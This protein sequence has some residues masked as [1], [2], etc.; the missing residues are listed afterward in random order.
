MAK[1]FHIKPDFVGTTVLLGGGKLGKVWL[2]K[3]CAGLFG[4]LG[5]HIMLITFCFCS[6]FHT[7]GCHWLLCFAKANYHR[8]LEVC[9]GGR[10]FFVIVDNEETGKA[11]LERGQL[12]LGASVLRGGLMLTMNGPNLP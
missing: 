6:L 3:T 12:R 4:R 1:L 10:L 2:A 8:A 7:G 11:L 9:A 5:N